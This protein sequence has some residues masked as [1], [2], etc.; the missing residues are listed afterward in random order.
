MHECQFCAKVDEKDFRWEN[1][2]AVAFAGFGH[3]SRY[4]E[5]RC[6]RLIAASKL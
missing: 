1:D 3:I 2:H 6:H 5:K 4:L